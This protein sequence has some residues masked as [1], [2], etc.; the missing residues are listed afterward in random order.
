MLESRQL[1]PLSPASTLPNPLSCSRRQKRNAFSSHGAPLDVSHE[2]TSFGAET[3]RQELTR[4][5]GRDDH[6][7]P[8]DKEGGCGAAAVVQGFRQD[9]RQQPC[10]SRRRGAKGSPV[11]HETQ[12]SR[13]ALNQSK[14]TQ[15]RRTREKEEEEKNTVP[16]R[17]IPKCQQMS[18]IMVQGC[19]SAHFPL[20]YS[21]TYKSSQQNTSPH[22]THA[23]ETPTKTKGDVLGVT[24][25]VQ[26][27]WCN[28]NTAWKHPT[29]AKR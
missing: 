13:R 29:D 11:P 24:L 21:S 5:H 10:R 23:L 17:E 12:T 18:T 2:R 25:L 7:W 3:K 4:C 14:D 16:R 8:E 27:N 6:D 26:F 20:Q 28:N 19:F 22:H 9:G 15:Q 1:G